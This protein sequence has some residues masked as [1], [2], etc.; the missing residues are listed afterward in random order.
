MLSPATTPGVVGQA[1]VATVFVVEDDP[2]MSRTLSR[3]LRAR[4]YRV[5]I[6]STGADARELFAEVQP[7]LIILDLML[8]DDDGLSLTVSFRTLTSAPIII[9]SARHGQLDRVLGAKLGAADFVAKPFELEDL[10]ARVEAALRQSRQPDG[11]RPDDKILLWS[12]KSSRQAG[13]ASSSATAGAP[14]SG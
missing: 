6:A 11:P 10:E 8:P 2:D 4:G 3:A 5:L 14:D 7:D 1:S 12:K 13:R 9:C